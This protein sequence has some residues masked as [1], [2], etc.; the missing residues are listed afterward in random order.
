[1]SRNTTRIDRLLA[2]LGYCSRR[3]A[4]SYI[5]RN[6]VTFEG[7]VVASASTHV[8]QDGAGVAI[9]D[10]P[11]L[12][13]KPLHILLHKPSGYVCTREKGE[14]KTV[15]DL[16]PPDFYKRRPLLNICGR[17]DRWVTGLVF[18][19]QDGQLQHQVVSPNRKARKRLG[20]TYV[21]KAWRDFKGDE[22]E[23][24]KAGT[25]LLNGE[26]KPCR[27]ADLEILDPVNNL[28]K[29]TLYE[30]KYHQIRRMFSAIG[31]GV[32]R[33]I[34][35]ISIGPL[36]LGNLEVGK[37]RHVTEEELRALRAVVDAGEAQTGGQREK[38]KKTNTAHDDDEGEKNESEHEGTDN[39]DDDNDV[40]GDEED[41]G[42]DDNDDDDGD[43]DLAKLWEAE[44]AAE[45]S[46]RPIKQQP[47]PEGKERADVK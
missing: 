47:E 41:L 1:M 7:E 3:S 2:N 20:K 19:T 37:W 39:D 29:V 21:I 6:R 25:L 30:G 13:T 17:L 23:I 40:D 26:T 31:N 44:H 24:F 22:A 5:R 35:R 10:E 34:A 27:P 28:A 16:L 36:Q 4:L 42:D 9:N 12:D 15:Y 18:L 33:S 32:P 46:R 8:P 38:T 11:L 43:R 45:E 14:H